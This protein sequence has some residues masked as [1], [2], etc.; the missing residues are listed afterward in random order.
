MSGASIPFSHR[1]R[2][3]LR[4]I[5][6]VVGVFAVLT[7]AAGKARADIGDTSGVLTG[8]VEDVDGAV[9]EP[10]GTAAETGTPVVQ[11]T[12]GS[13]AD[14]VG[15]VVDDATET[16]GDP[17]Q[18]VTG[19]ADQV[20]DETLS[21]VT[22]AVDVV[23]VTVEAVTEAVDDPVST[24]L[25]T[26]VD[27]VGGLPSGSL[28]PAADPG[29]ISTPPPGGPAGEPTP[30]TQRGPNGSDEPSVP[31]ISSP[32]PGD[33]TS[34]GVGPASSS[35]VPTLPERLPVGASSAPSSGSP[36]T[37]GLG[38]S[39]FAAFLAAAMALVVG[40]RRWLRLFADARAPNPF[41]SLVECPG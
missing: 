26:V 9:E 19:V 31:T 24:V 11:E 1:V 39:L 15:D 5:V 17:S 16:V 4:L 12:V 32:W 36:E 14:T 18:P 37:G 25:G 13:A 21:T 38:L 6:L 20:T 27:T 34:I 8:T 35:N 23:T 28:P 33:G 7:L 22:G 30:P 40:M 2:F 3:L 41:L 29:G 10:V